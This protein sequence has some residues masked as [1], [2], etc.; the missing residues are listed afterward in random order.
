MPT[1]PPA[2]HRRNCGWPAARTSHGRRALG[3]C[4]SLGSD[5]GTWTRRIHAPEKLAELFTGTRYADGLPVPDDRPAEQ[6]EAA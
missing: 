3:L 2:F 5:E 6:R 1:V 4:G